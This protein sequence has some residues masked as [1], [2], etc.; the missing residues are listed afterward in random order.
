MAD[1]A[2]CRL[3]GASESLVQ[4]H[5]IPSFV[6]AR[7]KEVSSTGYLRFGQTPN[8]RQQ[9]GPKLPFLCGPCEQHFNQWETPF[10]TNL[11]HP[12]HERQP[13]PFDYGPWLAK[14]GVS[15]IWR[16]LAYLL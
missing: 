11:F 1:E 12:F 16:A 4:S 10:A 7:H 14:C 6:F 8:R 2:S 15:V 5:I 13:P 3:C 9:D